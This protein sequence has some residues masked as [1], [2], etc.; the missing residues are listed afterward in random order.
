VT[1]RKKII[2]F[3]QILIFII[4]SL[5]IFFTY[6]KKDTNYFTNKAPQRIIEKTLDKTYDVPKNLN[7]NKNFNTFENVKYFGVDLNGNRYEI[8]SKYADFDVKIPELINMKIMFATF[9]FKDGKI[10]TVTGDYGTYNNKT[11]DM[12]FRDNVEAVYEKNY[13]YSDNLDYLS[14]QDILKIYGNVET[15]SVQ[16]ELKADILNFDLITKTLDVSMYKNGQV[17]VNLKDR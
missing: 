13:L 3:T 11:K 4:A 14:T 16:G 8:K 15:E 6:Y 17:N 12:S 1:Q 9:Y 10:L 7:E 2:L 5:L